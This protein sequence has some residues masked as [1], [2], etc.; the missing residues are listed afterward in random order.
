MIRL[1]ARILSTT[2]ILLPLH[3][4][5]VKMTSMVTPK[6]WFGLVVLL[7]LCLSSVTSTV[8]EEC[9]CL[10]NRQSQIVWELRQLQGT[11]G[12]LCNRA[13]SVLK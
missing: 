2:I 1:V 13:L 5:A 3:A 4:L 9:F 7:G 8:A 12:F 11:A 10:R 6:G